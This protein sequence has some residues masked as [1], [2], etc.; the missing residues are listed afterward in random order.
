M[1]DY[2]DYE[3]KRR[4]KREKR[5]DILNNIR[6]FAAIGMLLTVATLIIISGVD[7]DY[8]TWLFAIG[9]VILLLVG[10]LTR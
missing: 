8:F 6:F 1:N 10:L 9:F 3:E 2:N 7:L 5:A 4:K